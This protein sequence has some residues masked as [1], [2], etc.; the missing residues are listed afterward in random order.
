M[1]KLIRLTW[2]PVT[3]ALGACDV[4]VQDKTPA[5]YPANHDIGMYEIKATVTRDALVSPGSVFMFGLGDK[6]KVELTSN[7]DGSEWH[8]LYP[9]RCRASFPLQFLAIWK[10][11]GLE[12]KRKLVPPQPREIRLIDPPLT[13][14]APS[15]DTSGKSPKGGWEGSVQYKFVTAQNTRIT[16]AHIEPL[17][18]DAAD[19]AAAKPISVVSSFPVDAPCGTPTEIRVSSKAPRAHG[20]LVID[21]DYPAFPHWQTKVEFAPK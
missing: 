21:T 14:E 20:N 17:S 6:Q 12:T 15:V 13:R 16:A 2:I 7:R 4:Q 3:L 9:V 1:S 19:V 11:Q 18:Q 10:L 5:E 8:G